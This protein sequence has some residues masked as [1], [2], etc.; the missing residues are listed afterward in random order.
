MN[1]HLE[2]GLLIWLLSLLAGWPGVSAVHA[3]E[4]GRIIGTVNRPA[5]VTA[6]FAKD[7]L[8][9]EKDRVYPGKLDR[10][11]GRFVIDG[12]PLGAV[13]DCVIDHG[14]ARLEGVNLKVS[15]SDFE[16][17]QPLTREDV[18]ELKKTVL[19]TNKFE[20][21]IEFLTIRGNAQHA[22]VLLNKLRTK[23]FYESKPG[24]VIWRLE[25]WHFEKPDETWVKDQDELFIV[26]YRERLQR[27]DFDKKVVTF[28]AALGGLR[29]TARRPVI[30][31]G[32]V[33]LPRKE[34]GIRFRDR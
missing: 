20:D 5:T 27:K 13:Y 25:L 18:V 12:L 14:G 10:K 32:R 2:H 1:R 6:V 33:K 15:P 9:E 16:E 29:L 26:F 28:D 7:R 21:R 4:K 17:E 11:T 22:A 3:A 23:P 31:V 19:A 30:E 24:E 34:P 8:S